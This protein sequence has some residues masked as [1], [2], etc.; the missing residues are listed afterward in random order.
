MVTL[1]RELPVVIE[2][3]KSRGVENFDLRSSAVGPAWNIFTRYSKVVDADGSEMSSY[4]ASYLI[5][6]ELDA[7]LSAIYNQDCDTET[8]E[9]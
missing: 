1:K 2:D 9:V 6:Q 8:E 4:S 7:C 5:E 3:L